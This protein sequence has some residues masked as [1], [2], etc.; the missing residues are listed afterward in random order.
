MRDV[1]KK[2]KIKDLAIGMVLREI[3]LAKNN[4]ITA[5]EFRALYEGDKTMLKVANIYETYD[6][7]KSKTLLLDFD[8]LLVE[9][10]RLLSENDEVR[11]KQ[12][13]R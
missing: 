11:E 6:R 1:M 12:Q 7:E 8:D 2:L 5:D 3:S 9:T 13:H 10:Y 4:L